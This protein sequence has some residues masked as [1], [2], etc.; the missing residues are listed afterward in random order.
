MLE[1]NQL[2]PE[3]QEKIRAIRLRQ[4]KAPSYFTRPKLKEKCE[5]CGDT[6]LLQRHHIQYEPVEVITVCY[7]CH[8]LIH[9]RK[10]AKNSIP[11]EQN[12]LNRKRVNHN[13]YLSTKKSK[14]KRVETD[15]KK[16]KRAAT[17][18]KHYIKIRGDTK[19]ADEG[20]E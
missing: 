5:I 2:T 7:S 8:C 11:P 20:P 3:A 16:I 12:S 9:N 19:N 17:N 15:I 13:Y 10:L 14:V 1:V 4:Q 6:E 18:H